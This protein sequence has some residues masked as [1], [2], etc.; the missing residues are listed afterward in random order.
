MLARQKC[1]MPQ[2]SHPNFQL[3]SYKKIN[4]DFF[5]R[6][7]PILKYFIFS[8]KTLNIMLK[9]K[10]D[11]E[12]KISNKGCI[13][14]NKNSKANWQNLRDPSKT[15]VSLRRDKNPQYSLFLKR[16][17]WT[18][19]HW[20]LAPGRGSECR[21]VNAKQE[22]PALGHGRTLKVASSP[23]HRASLWLT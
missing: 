7:K 14:R 2:L 1:E 17:M 13:F 3:P 16:C 20:S 8:L 12:S 23:D 15:T 11:R 4:V 5:L 18:P 22:T 9:E 21:D 6:W 10:K 19:P